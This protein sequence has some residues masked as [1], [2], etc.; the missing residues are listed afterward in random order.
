MLENQ[1]V[2]KPAVDCPLDDIEIIEGNVSFGG[3]KVKKEKPE[4]KVEEIA[5]QQIV[6]DQPIDNEL[7]E[8]MRSIALDDEEQEDVLEDDPNIVCLTPFNFDSVSK[9]ESKDVFVCIYNSNNHN[10]EI[11]K[12]TQS[13]QD[14]ALYFKTKCPAPN[15][16][17]ACFDRGTF[18][19][20]EVSSEQ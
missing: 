7:I 8:Q 20:Q 5:E 15:L 4:E 16:I 18:D 3:P 13:I 19:I 9:D 14:T 6:E 10:K 1:G 2:A 11:E 12:V 17:I